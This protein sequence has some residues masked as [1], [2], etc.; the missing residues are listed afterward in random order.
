MFSSGATE[1]ER[2][3][4]GQRNNENNPAQRDYSLILATILLWPGYS[5]GIAPTP[6]AG[7]D[8]RTTE[9]D[10]WDTVANQ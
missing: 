9:S 5:L 4:T 8:V 3:T 2:A 7:L 6:A 1:H 10:L